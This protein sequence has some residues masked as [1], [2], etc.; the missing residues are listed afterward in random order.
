MN[1][2]NSTL[3]ITQALIPPIKA[4]TVSILLDYDLFN[5]EVRSCESDFW[6]FLDLLRTRKNEIFE[7]SITDRTRRLIS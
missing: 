6:S 2:I 7:S 5:E 1:D 3:I 4:N